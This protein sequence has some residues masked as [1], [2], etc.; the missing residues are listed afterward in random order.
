MYEVQFV[1]TS[2]AG[3]AKAIQL[4]D[5]TT[6][7]PMEDI[8]DATF[9]LDVRDSCGTQILTRSTA[10]DTIERPSVDTIQWIF[11]P[12]EMAGK[13]RDRTYRV[14]MTM[15]TEGGTIQLFI[16]TLTLLDGEVR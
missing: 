8:E 15:T 9:E 12:A 16:G 11:T 10:D 3:W 5:A 2:S 13:C 4:I 14:G 7:E 6:N 1:A